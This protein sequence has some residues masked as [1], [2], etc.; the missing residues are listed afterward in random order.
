MVITGRVTDA[1]LAVGPAAARFGWDRTDWDRLAGAV[2]AGHIL[3][4]GAQCTG[5]NYAFFAE[6][7]GLERPGFPLAEIHQDG[8]FVVT[9]HPGTGGLV[10][11]DTVTAQLLYEIQGPGYYNPDVVVAFDSIRLT[12]DGPDRVRVSGV[13]GR[14][15]PTSTKV[16][17]NYLGGYRNSVTF[18]LTGLDI[19]AKAELAERTLWSL[20]PGGQA[21]FEATDVV[22]RRTDNPDPATNADAI[23][24]LTVTVMDPDE[25]KVGRAFSN[26]AIEMV[27]A[28]YPGLFTSGP[29]TRGAS[30]GVYWPSL[31][32]A[33]VVP[34]EVVLGQERLAIEPVQV[35]DAEA[36]DDGD[37]Y[38]L[39]PPSTPDRA[40]PPDEPTTRIALGRIA[41]ARS[42]DKGGNANIGLWARNDEAYEWLA[43]YLTEERLGRLLAAEADGLAL[44]RYE[45][46]NLRAINVVVEGLLGR[47]V[48]ASTRIDPQAKGLGEYLRAKLVDVPTRLLSP[49]DLRRAGAP[50][51]PPP[52]RGRR[53]HRQ[54]PTTPAAEPTAPPPSSAP[55]PPDAPPPPSA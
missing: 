31:V 15:A 26:T 49:E 20:L 53:H 17:I 35:P 4:C 44:R 45:L 7:P 1:A 30:Y 16:A 9:K 21:G 46:P 24:E 5:G 43:A 12:D 29:P 10:S 13:T 33:E 50:P 19:E 6:V 23:A 42:G 55:P 36:G 28:N 39:T 2:V 51:P 14:P 40:A 22:L 38:G 25:T 11:V 47:G 41:G 37:R 32:P 52:P 8:S 18:L 34:H 54:E 3:E 27:L 48:A